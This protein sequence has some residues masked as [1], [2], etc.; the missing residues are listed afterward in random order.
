MTN[1]RF[2]IERSDVPAETAIASPVGPSARLLGSHPSISGLYIQRPFPPHHPNGGQEPGL[3]DDWVRPVQVSTPDIALQFV[4]CL[5]AA[6][7][8]Q[9]MEAMQLAFGLDADIRYD[10][11]NGTGSI[12]AWMLPSGNA[13]VSA[14]RDRG[15]SRLNLLNANE[16]FAFFLNS[17]Y[18][19]RMFQNEWAAR[20]KTLDGGGRPDTSGPIHLTGATIGFH[21]P[22]RIVVT[23]DGY[24]ERPW[25]DVDFTYTATEVLSVS[26]GQLQSDIDDDLDVDTT[27]LNV[28]TGI[29]NVVF[30]PLGIVFA[31][32]SIIIGSADAS[33]LGDSG[34]EGV[35]GIIP[36]AVMIDGGQKIAMDYNRV[37]VSSGGVFAGGTYS[38]VA[39]AP[40][41]EISGPSQVTM[42][43]AGGMVRRTYRIMTEDLRPPL[44]ISWSSERDVS[45]SNRH[46][47]SP[48]V[49]FTA[50]GQPGQ[51]LTRRLSVSVHDA[52]GLHADG[53]LTV[54]ISVQPQGGEIP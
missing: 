13:E 5:P 54:R 31:V 4:P 49:T 33:D 3:P 48:R 2:K 34:F 37:A 46:S 50:V 40:R 29:F 10:C 53:E 43:I 19:R 47:A 35:A 9:L 1:K 7:Q 36:Q 45:F 39:R 52:D 30:L 20:P 17:A 22:D 14:A 42:A 8:D 41:A 21:S 24:D 26:N 51:V 6:F 15:L 11:I 12:G 27:W 32:Q 44:Q 23:V 16:T 28:L 25:P 18:V 38:L